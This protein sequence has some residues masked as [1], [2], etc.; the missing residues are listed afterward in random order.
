MHNE[1][2][3]PVELS[4]KLAD[5]GF[6]VKTGLGIFTPDGTVNGFTGT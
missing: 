6:A 2:L 4:W 1:Y 5:S 3:V